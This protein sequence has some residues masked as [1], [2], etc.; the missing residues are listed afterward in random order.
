MRVWQE[1]GS[2]DAFGRAKMRVNELLATYQRPVLAS[3]IER[4]LVE[5]VQREAQTAGLGI[6]PG[7]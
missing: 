5:L 4:E 1:G 3:D 2:L 6:L 7:V